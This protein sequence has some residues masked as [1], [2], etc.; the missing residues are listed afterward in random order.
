[1][2][3]TL[4]VWN[5]PLSWSLDT[6]VMCVYTPRRKCFPGDAVEGDWN[7]F[8]PYSIKVLCMYL[9]SSKMLLSS[10]IRLGDDIGGAREQQYAA[11]LQAVSA[12]WKSRPEFVAV[13]LSF[14]LRQRCGHIA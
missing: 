12:C 9:Q 8:Q 14:W 4:T 11:A 3:G 6:K 13:L 5:G 1:M 10:N 7:D 2:L